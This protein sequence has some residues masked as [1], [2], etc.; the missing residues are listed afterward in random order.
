MCHG[1]QNRDFWNELPAM[2]NDGIQFVSSGG[3]SQAHFSQYAQ[4]SEAVPKKVR[5][6]EPLSTTQTLNPNMIDC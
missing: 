2:V 3:Q 4:V 1:A 5:Q 6:T